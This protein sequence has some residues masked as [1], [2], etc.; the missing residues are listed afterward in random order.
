MDL[1]LA[2]KRKRISLR[3]VADK[4]HYTPAYLHDLE[5]GR[6]AW[7]ADLINK[8]KKAIA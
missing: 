5:L 7:N 3:A 6:R 1:R 4:L 2:R 8:Y